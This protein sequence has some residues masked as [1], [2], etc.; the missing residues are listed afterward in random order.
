MAKVTTDDGYYKAIAQAIR[1]EAPDGSFVQAKNFKPADMVLGVH[2]LCSLVEE[3]GYQRGLGDGEERGIAKGKQSE[4]DCFWDALQ[5]NGSSDIDLRYMFFS[6]PN[7]IY[8]PKYPIRST[9]INAQGVFRQSE[10]TST[11]VDVDFSGVSACSQAFYDATEL[12]TIPKLIVGENTGFSATFQNC[13]SL[14]ELTIEGV[15]GQSGLNLQWSTKLSKG[16]IT[17]VVNALSVTTSGLA[18][19]FS[20]TAVNTAFETSAGAAD[21]SVSEEWAILA[22]T[23]TNWTIS[24]IDSV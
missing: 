7:A 17:S 8:K 3:T 5:R 23:K 24:L 6:W 18:V 4:Y 10:I 2:D 15:V 20:K 13:V 22:A 1:D 12:I 16:S 19:T 9:T 11:L 14:V 21:G